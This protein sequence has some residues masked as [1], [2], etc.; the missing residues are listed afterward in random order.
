MD[1][2]TKLARLYNAK[3]TPEMFVIDPQGK[4]IYAGAIDDRPTTDPEDVHGAHNYVSDA[5][6]EAM[7]GKPV[8]TP[9]TRSYGCS[10]KYPD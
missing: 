10:V 4:L 7:A 5:L 2:Q 3:T 8:A 9:Y 1:P 6:T